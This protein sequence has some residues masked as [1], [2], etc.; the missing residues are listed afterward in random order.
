MHGIQN[1]YFSLYRAFMFIVES[2]MKKIQ[3]IL[4]TGVMYNKIHCGRLEHTA[5]V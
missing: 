1:L 5:V 3:I 4:E 2:K